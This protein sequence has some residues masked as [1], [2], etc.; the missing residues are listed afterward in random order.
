MS[1]LPQESVDVAE[2]KSLCRVALA[3]KRCSKEA[4]PHSRS[5][6]FYMEDARRLSPWLLYSSKADL[7][8]SG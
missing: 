4:A 7:T 6:D 2:R 1:V 3:C 8:V 5:L